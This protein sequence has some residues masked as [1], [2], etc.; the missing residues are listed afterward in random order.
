M[1]IKILKSVKGSDRDESGLPLPVKLYQKDNVYDV[2]AELAKSLIDAKFA[3]NS[4]GEISP[5]ENQD[6]PVEEKYESPSAAR[7][8]G[9]KKAEKKKAGK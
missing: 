8:A 6:M 4:S 9:F 5:E 7:E 3:L 2:G 1:K